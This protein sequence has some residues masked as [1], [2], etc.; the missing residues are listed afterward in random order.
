[1]SDAN[2]STLARRIADRLM[3][4][5]WF[6]ELAWREAGKEGGQAFALTLAQTI[7]RELDLREVVSTRMG[8]IPP[9]YMPP[10]E[11]VERERANVER[12]LV[13]AVMQG[14]PREIR[15]SRDE[16]GFMTVEARSYIIAG[17]RP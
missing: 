5:Q 17:I 1:M 2:E 12:D 3:L 16:R 9:D 6:R 4:S 13:N 10:P 8:M 7:E 15:L 11:H 14:T